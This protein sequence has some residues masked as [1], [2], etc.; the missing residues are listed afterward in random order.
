MITNILEAFAE[1][2]DPRREHPLTLHKLIDI[3]VIAVCA[4]IAKSDTWEEIADYGVMKE[5]FLRQFLE[6]AYGIPSH[7]TFTRV[8]ARLDPQAWQTCFM[9]WMRSV[10]QVSEDKLISIDGKVLRG[11]KSKGQGKCEAEQAALTM[12]SAWASENELVL[13]Q[14]AL[15]DNGHE[16]S[17]IPEL[18][19]LPE[20]EGASV[21]IDAAG[22][23]KEIAEQIV[24][25]GADYVLALKANHGQLFDEA[26]WLFDYHRKEAVPMDK[27]ETFDVAH[28][29]E[30]TRTCW[31]LSDLSYLGGA[32]CGL[33]DWS[34][35]NAIIV[36]DSKVLRQAKESY[37]RR[38][39]LTSHD[40]SASDALTRVRKHW[41]IENQQHYPLDVLFREDAARTRKG[42]AAQ[43][44]ASLRR[45]A[46]N[47]L[48]LED[49]FT[50]SKRRKRLKALLDDNYLLKLL[51]LS[52]AT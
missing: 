6:L 14:L 11:S 37:K 9:R 26:N 41:S 36:L 10:S 34:Q 43:N 32:D 40:F 1:L 8:F 13:A 2:P 49:A 18:L 45:L 33:R 24:G 28:G 50:G 44:L 38:F 31:L 15:E 46:L 27:A 20:L 35:L 3:V 17:I 25:Q 21:S 30:E 5:G 42:F 39:F 19:N 7:D 52:G 29:R 4:T 48:N 12:V 16:L 23:H 47:L 22:C 51:G